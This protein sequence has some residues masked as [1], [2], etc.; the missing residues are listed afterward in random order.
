MC[1]KDPAE[2]NNQVHRN[3]TAADL[4]VGAIAT[5]SCIG[6]SISYGLFF[7]AFIG[8]KVC[9]IHY[10]IIYFQLL[11]HQRLLA[12]KET[13]LIDKRKDQIV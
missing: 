4:G 11:A 9:I 8:E 3:W 12:E 6:N 5:Y 10:V 2:S 13:L 7:P 1:D